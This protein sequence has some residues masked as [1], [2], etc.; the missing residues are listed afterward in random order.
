MTEEGWT[1]QLK[2]GIFK[3]KKK[4]YNTLLIPPGGAFQW[5]YKVKTVNNSFKNVKK[6]Q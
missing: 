2:F 5:R 1:V 6:Y 3:K 4:Q